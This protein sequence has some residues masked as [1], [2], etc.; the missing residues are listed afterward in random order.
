MQILI[1]LLKTAFK[2]GSQTN[3]WQCRVYP[4]LKIVVLNMLI[5]SFYFLNKEKQILI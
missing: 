2:F 4:I 3:K 1:T 5:I